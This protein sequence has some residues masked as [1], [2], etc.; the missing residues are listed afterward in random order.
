MSAVVGRSL[1]VAFY[2]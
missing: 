2:Y 1:R